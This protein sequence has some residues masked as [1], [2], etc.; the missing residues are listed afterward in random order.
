[1]NVTNHQIWWQL[2][3]A[4]FGGNLSNYIPFDG[5]DPKDNSRKC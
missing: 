2:T 4:D 3:A 1:M 5:I